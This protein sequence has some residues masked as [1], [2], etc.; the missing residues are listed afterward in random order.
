MHLKDKVCVVTGAA[1]GIGEAVARA[2]AQAG[3][4]GVVVADLKSSRDR[5]AKVAGDIDAFAVTADVG[6]E[7]DIKALIAAAEA[8]YGPID[9]LEYSP[10][11]HTP[12]K[13]LREWMPTTMTIAEVEK[14][15]RLSCYGAM[16]CANLVLPDMLACRSGTILITISGSG[17]EPIKTLAAVGISMAAARNYGCSLYQELQGKGVYAG[18]IC[19]SLLID[20]GDP[21]GDPNTLA[22]VY[23]DMHVKRD[24]P[25][26]NITTPV[27]PHHHHLDDMKKY[28]IEM[29]KD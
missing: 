16:V 26:F 5:L 7:A 15:M 20:E 1:S 18:V 3:A 10:E 9:V 22:E 19:L 17:I 2:Y 23:W 25:E 4:R 29:P 13:D 14:R 28:G 24:R 8:K 21:Y 11:P 6:Q 12:P 27:D